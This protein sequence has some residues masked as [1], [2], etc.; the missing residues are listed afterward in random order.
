MILAKGE[1]NAI[2]CYDWLEWEDVT[3]RE[4]V[5]GEYNAEGLAGE[6][7]N[8]SREGWVQCYTV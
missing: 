2:Q 3:G 6:E 1:S 5:T 7:A 8:A 4:N